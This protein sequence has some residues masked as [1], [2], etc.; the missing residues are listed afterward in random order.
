MVI[1]VESYV[2]GYHIYKKV[3]TLKFADSKG[4]REPNRQICCISIERNSRRWTFKKKMISKI[5][6]ETFSEKFVISRVF[7]IKGPD[8]WFVI[9]KVR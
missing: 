1:N 2:E 8:I 7:M 4:T 5:I 9:S 6:N 3:W